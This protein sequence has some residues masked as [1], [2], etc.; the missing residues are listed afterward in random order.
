[1][2]RAPPGYRHV[3]STLV[4]TTRVEI[5]VERCVTRRERDWREIGRS[6]RRRGNVG[7]WE[8]RG[9]KKRDWLATRL[10]GRYAGCP[11]W[12]ET[13]EG[14]T[15]SLWGGYF[16]SLSLSY[17]SWS[18]TSTKLPFSFSPFALTFSPYRGLRF[19]VTVTTLYFFLLTEN[20]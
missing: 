7:E 12:P 1:M 8:Y 17:E 6:E 5:L 20:I 10:R 16:E 15:S 13:W 19:N 18:I 3:S 2:L 4:K 9:K 14:A 11:R